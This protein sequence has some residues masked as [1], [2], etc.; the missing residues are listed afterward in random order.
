MA[1]W[2]IGHFYRSPSRLSAATARCHPDHAPQSVAENP[3]NF[4]SWMRILP[5]RQKGISLNLADIDADPALLNRTRSNMT[6]Y[7]YYLMVAKGSGR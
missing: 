6:I 4:R 1:H 5:A 7:R 2:D 3:I